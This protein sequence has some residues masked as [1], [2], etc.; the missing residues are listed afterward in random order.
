MQLIFLGIATVCPKPMCWQESMRMQLTRNSRTTSIQ[1]IPLGSW[2]LSFEC[3]CFHATMQQNIC[4]YP[5][6][7]VIVYQN[8]S[9]FPL[10][11]KWSHF[12]V[13]PMW[14]CL[15]MGY[16]LFMT[17]SVG[18]ISINHWI[19]GDRTALTK[20]DPKASGGRGLGGNR[21][22]RVQVCHG[23]QWNGNL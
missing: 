12:L 5:T 7:I 8:L 16:T 11:K 10:Q 22:G 19:W 23:I 3:Y 21:N 15:K 1:V 4:G 18:N 13:K 17:T 9:P 14:V 2:N 6:Q 20:P